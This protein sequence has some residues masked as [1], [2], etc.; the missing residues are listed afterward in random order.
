MT[1]YE[2]IINDNS[3]RF[4]HPAKL[5]RFIDAYVDRLPVNG[6]INEHVEKFLPVTPSEILS[7]WLFVTACHGAAVGVAEPCTSVYK[8]MKADLRTYNRAQLA[9]DYMRFLEF[10]EQ[11]QTK[12]QI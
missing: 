6:Y 12:E 10:R 7:E 5:T 3:S 4:E 1:D 8:L 2:K 9:T 11:Q